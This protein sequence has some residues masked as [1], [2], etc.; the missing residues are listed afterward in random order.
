MLCGLFLHRKQSDCAF[1]EK[2]EGIVGM[3]GGRRRGG[4]RERKRKRNGVREG[5]E[6]DGGKDGG[7]GGIEGADEG[8]CGRGRRKRRRRE[9]RGERGDKNRKTG[10]KKMPKKGNA[11]ARVLN[12]R[13]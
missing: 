3:G 2:S 12:I 6:N 5:R 10:Q 7:G 1:G 8:G 13:L 4:V 9:G 11:V